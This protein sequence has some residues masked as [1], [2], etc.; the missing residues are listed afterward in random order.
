MANQPDTCKPELVAP[1]VV[2]RCTDAA[3]DSNGRDFIVGGGELSL[4]ALPE[5]E[6]TLYSEGGWT[7]EQLKKLLPRTLGAGLT[8]PALS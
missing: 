5:K 4:V 7:L 6:R 2:Y 1:L 3:A 8:N